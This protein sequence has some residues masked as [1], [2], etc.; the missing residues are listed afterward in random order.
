MQINK[1]SQTN[2]N[3]GVKIKANEN[4]AKKYLYNEV[5]DITKK[6]KIPATFMTHEIDLP[7][8]SKLVL[9]RLQELGIKYTGLK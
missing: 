3:A 5:N 7:T 9:A 4:T 8:V 2:F 1:I 6:Y